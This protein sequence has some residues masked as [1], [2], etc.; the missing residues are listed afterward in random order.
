MLAAIVPAFLLAR[1]RGFWSRP[2]GGISDAVVQATGISLATVALVLV[3]L[4]RITLSTPLPS[5]LG[6]TVYE[7]IPFALGAA[8][9]GAAIQGSADAMSNRSGSSGRRDS[10]RN[11]IRD[12]G[13]TA[14]GALFL[15][16]VIAPTE[17]VPLLAATIPLPWLLAVIALSYT[18][19]FA[20]GFLDE[21][22]RRAQLGLLQR[23]LTETLASY[24][25]ALAVS[26]LMLGVFDNL[27][28]DAPVD[29]TLSRVIVLGLPAAIGG[30]SGRLVV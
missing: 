8:V 23:P 28:L 17:E 25:V 20:S 18:I 14:I 19:V 6:V 11:T 30:S 4:Q 24:L 9:A 26:A 15:G 2:A 16:L 13:V 12:L 3:A 29:E 10:A 27:A 22:K 21:R 5:A 1:V 7:A